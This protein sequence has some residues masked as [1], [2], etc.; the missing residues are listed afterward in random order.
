MVA[1]PPNK[2]WADEVDDGLDEPSTPL[3]TE[4][5][6]PV[7]G[8]KTIVEYKTDDMG[9]KVK[10]TRQIRSIIARSLVSSAAAE[11]KQIPKFGLEK[12]K[13]P[14]PDSSTTT[15]G[16]D[17]RLL[18]RQ[19][20]HKAEPEVDETTALK[21]S[22]LA[23]KIT[24]RLC[25]GD[26]YTTRCPYKDTLGGVLP[27]A[28]GGDEFGAGGGDAP[29]ADSAPAAGSSGAG[30]KYVPP[31]MRDGAKGR[32]ESMN[33]SRNRDDLPTLRVTNL[34]EDTREEDVWELFKTFGKILRVFVGMDLDLGICKGF[35][36]V[37]F[38]DRRE[39]EK[40][41]EKID[42]KPYDH[43]ILSCQFSTPRTDRKDGA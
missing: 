23:K 8:I 34:S 2:S 12:G 31:S 11:R 24:C 27:D 28:E 42:G 10:V 41:R 7:T 30:G 36:F 5:T 25:Q 43:L 3:R 15:L 9:R 16:E 37:T 35:A 17:F 18:L 32:G 40:A 33:S 1:A 13:K 38:E 19:G 14:G 21:K 20:G 22:L 29:A 26:H 4:T 6:D 39:A